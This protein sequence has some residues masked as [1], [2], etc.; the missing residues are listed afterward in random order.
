MAASAFA[1]TASARSIAARNSSLFQVSIEWPSSNELSVASCAR[2]TKS[3][4][5]AMA[6]ESSWASVS[7]RKTAS[8][9]HHARSGTLKGWHFYHT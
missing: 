8:L 1:I 4:S 7:L 2:D 9:T 3:R 5:A 6:S